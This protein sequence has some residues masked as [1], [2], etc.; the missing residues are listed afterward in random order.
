MLHFA[1]SAAAA[2]SGLLLFWTRMLT[3]VVSFACSHSFL[4]LYRLEPSLDTQWVRTTN[5]LSFPWCCLR[6][7]MSILGEDLQDSTQSAHFPDSNLHRPTASC[8]DDKPTSPAPL[9]PSCVFSPGR[10]ETHSRQNSIAQSHSTGYLPFVQL[11]LVS[12]T[13]AA[14]LNVWDQHNS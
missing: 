9:S 8:P 11:H 3:D 13:T 6:S 5:R 4:P 2:R 7:P 10:L 1:A 14:T 12:K